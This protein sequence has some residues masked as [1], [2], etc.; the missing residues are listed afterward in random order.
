MS[1]DPG[2][3]GE[4]TRAGYAGLFLAGDHSASATVWRDGGSREALTGIV[5]DEQG[6]DLARLLASEVLYRHDPGYP[7]PGWSATLAPVYARAL[8]LTGDHEAGLPLTGNEW[9]FLYR[10][11]GPD[12]EL[13]THLLATGREAVPYLSALLDDANPILYVG[14]HDAT[15]GNS[16][17]YRVKDA[18]AYFIGKATGTPVR[19]HEDTTERDAEIERLR[20]TLGA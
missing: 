12:G 15:L 11:V 16:L 9:G 18:A 13:G 14:S 4:L 7:P 17:H 3:A 19:F 8:A 1:A 5:R 6:D 10:E 20:G 2:L